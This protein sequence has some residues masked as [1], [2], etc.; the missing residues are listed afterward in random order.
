VLM[1]FLYC[2]GPGISP[3]IIIY[4]CLLHNQGG[5][6]KIISTIGH[7]LCMLLFKKRCYCSGKDATVQERIHAICAHCDPSIPRINDKFRIS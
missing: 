3:N 1:S 7:V 6:F 2:C 5:R 4:F